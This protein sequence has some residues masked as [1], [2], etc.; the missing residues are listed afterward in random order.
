MSLITKFLLATGVTF[1]TAGSAFAACGPNNPNCLSWTSANTTYNQASSWST[2]AAPA[3]STVVP[4][5]T[6]GNLSVSS[7]SSL[8][9]PGLGPNER[10]CPTTCPVD[11]HNP[12]GGKVLDC[13]SVCE[14]VAAPAPQPVIQPAVSYNIVRV[15]RPIVYVRYQSPVTAPRPQCVTVQRPSYGCY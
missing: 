7:V 12:E 5:S 15:V 6:P 2:H 10:L 14:P 8:T 13:Y 4:F 3:Q 9:V 11:V 1:F